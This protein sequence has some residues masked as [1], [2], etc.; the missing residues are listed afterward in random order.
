MEEPS[1]ST[2]R[3]STEK[4]RTALVSQKKFLAGNSDGGV[5]H[6]QG[7]NC[8][9]LPEKVLAGNSNGGV[10]HHGDDGNGMHFWQPNVTKIFCGSWL[11]TFQPFVTCLH[12][13]G[14]FNRIGTGNL[15]Y[16]ARP[17]VCFNSDRRSGASPA[18][19]PLIA[20]MGTLPRR[21]KR[22]PPIT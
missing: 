20:A 13:W 18:T 17:L 4:G 22:T 3:F 19:S 7:P 12:L 5:F 21:T 10:G 11:I 1:R 15:H 9:G 6:R 8:L 2:S 14:W 16:L